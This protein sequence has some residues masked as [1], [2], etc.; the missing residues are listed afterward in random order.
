MPCRLHRSPLPE[1][2]E[3]RSECFTWLGCGLWPM[4]TTRY[5]PILASEVI[6]KLVDGLFD[7]L[8]VL[9]HLPRFP[10][11][12]GLLLLLSPPLGLD[13]ITDDPFHTDLRDLLLQDWVCCQPPIAQLFGRVPV[14]IALE[15]RL[16]HQVT[17]GLISLGHHAS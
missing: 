12:V 9:R 14:S 10:Q 1:V 15:Q 13:D 5:P 7:L 16:A 8:I 17:H 11:P 2:G 4:G 3:K 6:E